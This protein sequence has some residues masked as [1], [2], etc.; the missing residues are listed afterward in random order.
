MQSIFGNKTY[1]FQFV[2]TVK[3]AFLISLFLSEILAL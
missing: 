2:S 3:N 1:L